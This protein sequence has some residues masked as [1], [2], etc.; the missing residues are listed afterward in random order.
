MFL[1]Q[2]AAGVVSKGAL[3]GSSQIG[4]GACVPRGLRSSGP[5]TGGFFRTSL[6]SRLPAGSEVRPALGFFHV[7]YRSPVPVAHGED[8]R[9][10]RVHVVS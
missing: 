5:G 4:R 8:N 2:G 9:S 6:C 10:T 1:S 3:A 7:Q